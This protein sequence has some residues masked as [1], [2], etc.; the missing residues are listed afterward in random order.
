MFSE[1]FKF[2]PLNFENEILHVHVFLKC[3]QNADSIGELMSSGAPDDTCPGLAR[4][5]PPGS[6]AA[7]LCPSC[8]A[9]LHTASATR[10]EFVELTGERQPLNFPLRI[11]IE[12][13]EEL[14]LQHLDRL[15]PKPVF[16]TT[17][18]FRVDDN[19]ELHQAVSSI[20]FLTI[21]MA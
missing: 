5:C 20:V 17:A 7:G 8:G 18:F 12:I 3:H 14:W 11:S 6:E 1:F 10:T 9:I 13:P 2:H 19:G 15:D 16:S 21:D 4:R